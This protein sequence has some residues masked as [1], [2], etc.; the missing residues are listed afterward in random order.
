M[1]SLRSFLHRLRK[2]QSAKAVVSPLFSN[3]N[4]LERLK[5]NDTSAKPSFRHGKK[6]PAIQERVAA[7]NGEAK[8]FFAQ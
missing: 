4:V 7:L 2:C 8:R 3:L 1:V 6:T 5:P